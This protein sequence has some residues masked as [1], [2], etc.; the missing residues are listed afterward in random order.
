MMDICEISPSNTRKIA[1]PVSSD[2][3]A[4]PATLDNLSFAVGSTDS[5][6]DDKTESLPSHTLRS[7]VVQEHGLEKVIYE[8]N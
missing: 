3:K 7:H 5:T 6:M 4:R 2:H 1:G 8:V